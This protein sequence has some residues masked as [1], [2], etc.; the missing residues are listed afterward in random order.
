MML[1]SLSSVSLL[2]VDDDDNGNDVDD[3]RRRCARRDFGFSRETDVAT[4][5][6]DIYKRRIHNHFTFFREPT[7]RVRVLLFTYCMT[8]VQYQN[9]PVAICRWGTTQCTTSRGECCSNTQTRVCWGVFCD[10][11]EKCLLSHR[12]WQRKSPKNQ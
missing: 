5:H 2:L 6:F 3:L 11:L 9:F 10:P 12:K 4:R 7:I 1:S 8:R